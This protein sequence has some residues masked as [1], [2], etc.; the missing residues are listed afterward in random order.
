M[1]RKIIISREFKQE[2]S[3]L[4]KTE[5]KAIINA[6]LRMRRDPKYPGLRIKKMQKCKNTKIYGK[7]ALL[8]ICESYFC[9]MDMLFTSSRADP[10][11]WRIDK[12]IHA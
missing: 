1:N 11:K 12:N 9:L 7:G 8:V 4:T 5:R 6:L 3:K 10:I 2:Y